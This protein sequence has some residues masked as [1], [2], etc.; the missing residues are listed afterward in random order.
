MFTNENYYL[1]QESLSCVARS[2]LFTGKPNLAA[3][4][5]SK[6]RRL[7]ANVRILEKNFQKGLATL[8]FQNVISVIISY[9]C[10][11]ADLRIMW[12]L[13]HTFPVSRASVTQAK[14][15]QVNVMVKTNLL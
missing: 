13:K 15:R 4:R 8:E 5:D 12:F 6:W 7:Q 1:G 3:K 11:M 10:S 9:S 2:R 14:L